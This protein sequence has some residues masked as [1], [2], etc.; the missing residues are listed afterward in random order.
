MPCSDFTAPGKY[1]LHCTVVYCCGACRQLVLLQVCA[2]GSLLQGCFP[3]GRGRPQ[4]HHRRKGAGPHPAP[5]GRCAGP[6][7]MLLWA[8][9]ALYVVWRG[10]GRDGI[11][12]AG[13]GA[14]VLG[15]G[16]NQRAARNDIWCGMVGGGKP[17]T[18]RQGPAQPISCVTV[19]LIPPR[20]PHACLFGSPA[21]GSY[22]NL[23]SDLDLGFG[24]R[25]FQPGSRTGEM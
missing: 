12:A 14:G 6:P 7:N 13:S 16:G 17:P 21:A 20:C 23:F 3:G 8:L 11:A 2:G 25:P 19:P 5:R 9:A 1:Q 10:V 22:A 18:L 24:S 4:R 15:R